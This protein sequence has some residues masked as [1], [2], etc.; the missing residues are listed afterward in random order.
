M[1]LDILLIWILRLP[2]LLSEFKLTYLKTQSLLLQKA[3]MTGN[4]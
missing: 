4:F 3:T 2:T 1:G